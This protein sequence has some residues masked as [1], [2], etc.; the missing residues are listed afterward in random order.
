MKWTLFI[1]QKVKV[2]ALLLC[3]MFFVMLTSLLGN[4]NLARINRA[5]NTIYNDRLIPA[6]DVYYIS[7]NLHDKKSMLESM[8]H[9]RNTAVNETTMKK[10]DKKINTLL[11][12][13]EHTYLVQGEARFIHDFKNSYA[14]YNNAE[15]SVMSL[16]KAGEFSAAQ[17]VYSNA[18]KSSHNKNIQVLGELMNIQSHVGKDIIKQSELNASIF[19][20]LSK[21]QIVVAIVVGILVTR[22]V[23]SSRIAQITPEKYTMN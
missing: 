13:Y 17:L 21:L 10:F 22:L 9:A 18:I 5:V 14:A 1:Q 16:I 20:L 23:M 12:H 11:T 6:S 19:S 3:V 2:A 7:T 15:A 8:L 4:T